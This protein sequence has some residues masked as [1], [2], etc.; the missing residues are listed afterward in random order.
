M[1]AAAYRTACLAPSGIFSLWTEKIYGF[2]KKGIAFSKIRAR[3]ELR[4]FSGAL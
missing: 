1:T 2:H 3:I 4:L